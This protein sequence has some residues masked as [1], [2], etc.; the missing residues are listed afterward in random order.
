M[1]FGRV[2]IG[3][4]QCATSGNSSKFR[5]GFNETALRGHAFVIIE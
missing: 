4:R 3:D 1:A 2:K 5:S